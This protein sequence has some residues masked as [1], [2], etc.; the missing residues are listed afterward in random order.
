LK[1]GRVFRVRSS[2]AGDATEVSGT[3]SGELPSRIAPL[4]ATTFTEPSG[5]A[6]WQAAA[7][8]KMKKEKTYLITLVP[9]L[10]RQKNSRWRAVES[11]RGNTEFRSHVS[12]LEIALHP[13]AGRI[14]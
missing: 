13:D 2:F 1:T 11:P 14:W 4:R 8:K 7:S 5:S 10:V 12:L 3:A 6:E 9:A